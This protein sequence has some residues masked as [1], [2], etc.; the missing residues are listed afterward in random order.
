MEH[1][2]SHEASEGY[3]DNPGTEAEDDDEDERRPPPALK[4]LVPT[5]GSA[6][7]KPVQNG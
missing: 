4:A 1:E 7:E 5:I 3:P 6:S 2:S